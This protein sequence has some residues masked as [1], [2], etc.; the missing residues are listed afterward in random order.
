MVVKNTLLL[1]SVPLNFF[2][3]FVLPSD[4]GS[5]VIVYAGSVFRGVLRARRCGEECLGG[6]CVGVEGY[7]WNNR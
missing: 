4:L 1:F 7:G 3:F 5:T 6:W 2:W